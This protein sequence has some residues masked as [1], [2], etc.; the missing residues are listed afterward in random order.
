MPETEDVFKQFES[1]GCLDAIE[2]MQHHPNGTIYEMAQAI[3]N[4]YNEIQDQE[5][6]DG[7]LN[8]A[9]ASTAASA[10]ALQD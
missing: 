5:Q 3:C 9:G 4:Y 6:A 2:S 10:I 8:A 1:R 7:E